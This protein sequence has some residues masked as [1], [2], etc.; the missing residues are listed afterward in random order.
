MVIGNGMVA[1]AFNKFLHNDKVC[2]FASGVSNSLSKDISQFERERS[3]IRQVNENHRDSLLIY[4]SSCALVSPEYLN[5]PYYAHKLNMET[6]VKNNFNRYIILRLPQVFGNI[7]INKPT[8]IDYLYTKILR[9]EEIRLFNNAKRYVIDIIDVVDF[10]TH[11]ILSK[12]IN[13]TIDLANPYHY[14]IDDIVSIIEKLVS[15]QAIVCKVDKEDD[16]YK[17]DLSKFTSLAY[18]MSILSEFG[19]E[20]L[21]K[22]LANKLVL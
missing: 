15:K 18:D 14:K 5:I 22:R 7:T 2:I 16:Y 21:G 3:L 6:Y 10:V 1:A 4:F 13:Q 9:E 17:L 20:Y 19:I 11:I 12:K 8:L